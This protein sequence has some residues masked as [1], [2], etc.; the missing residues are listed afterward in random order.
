MWD[1]MQLSGFGKWWGDEAGRTVKFYIFCMKYYSKA[2]ID[3]TKKKKKFD[4]R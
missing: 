3:D 1:G 2:K 4:I